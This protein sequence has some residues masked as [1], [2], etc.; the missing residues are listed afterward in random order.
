MLNTQV[1][2]NLHF[3]ERRK[4][5]F[6]AI[7]NNMMVLCLMF[8]PQL[9]ILHI[10]T[11][12]N[13][14]GSLFIFFRIL[15]IYNQPFWFCF[16]FTEVLLKEKATTK[17]STLVQPKIFNGII[18]YTKHRTVNG[19]ESNGELYKKVK[20]KYKTKTYTVSQENGEDIILQP[21]KEKEKIFILVKK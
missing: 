10:R 12:G 6:Y 2:P 17:Q 13:Y 11:W 3:N 8:C 9:C 20:R 21:K 18:E 5:E 15:Y 14:P 19:G 16:G 4:L 7:E 1:N